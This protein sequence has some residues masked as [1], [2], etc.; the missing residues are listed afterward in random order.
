[1]LMQQS[2]LSET[3]MQLSTGKKYLSPSD[4][5]AATSN[6]LD[7]STS[8]SVTKQYEANA[9]SVVSRLSAEES[10]LGGSVDIMDRL[11]ELAIQGQNGTLSAPDRTVLGE[12]ALQLLDSMVG[13]A[14]TV[15]PN[16]DYLFSGL[17]SQTLP[18]NKTLAAAGPPAVYNFPW[19]GNAVP[20]A[21][22][23]E[24][25][26][27]EIGPSRSVADGDSGYYVFGSAPT[28]AGPTQDIFT[29][30]Q[31]FANNMLSNTP[32]SSD[33]ADLELA[34]QRLRTVRSNVGDRLNAVDDQSGINKAY[35]LQMQQT[36]SQVQDLDYTEAIS[37]LNLQTQS[38]QAAQQSY[39]KVQGL[40]LFNYLR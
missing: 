6:A 36:L 26:T 16:G 11:K 34:T 37:K 40:S 30:I 39:I 14:N 10:V 29:T 35:V 33:I 18:F 32:Q 9:K 31:K 21:P 17:K 2:K 25:R 3:Q 13:L 24:Q 1:M 20:P 38:L 5:V 7:I 8:L 28:S 22:A 12:E 23:N 4:N 27:I 19:Q 15:G